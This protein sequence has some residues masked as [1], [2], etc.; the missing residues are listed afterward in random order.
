L[1]FING[2]LLGELRHS[3]LSKKHELLDYILVKTKQFKFQ[4]VERRIQ[5]M[6]VYLAIDPIQLSDHYPIE[7]IFKW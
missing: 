7:G 1:N 6:S 3:S 5:N 4:S 2:P